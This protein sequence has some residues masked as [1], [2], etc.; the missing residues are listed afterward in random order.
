[1]YKETLA[2]A[3]LPQLHR[4]FQIDRDELRDAAFGHGD[5]EQ[6]V[7]AR[8][9]DWVVGDDDKAR[10]GRARHLVEEVAEALDIVIVQ[11]R[12]ERRRLSL[13]R[14]TDVVQKSSLYG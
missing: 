8:H 3:R 2:S 5:A 11:R 10:L 7:H 4:A 12:T 13:V 6:A 9:G 14:R 1:M